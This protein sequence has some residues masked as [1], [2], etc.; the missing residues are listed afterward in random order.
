[1]SDPYWNKC[2]RGTAVWH[3]IY[4]L[5]SILTYHDYLVTAIGYNVNM[6][7]Q[8][9]EWLQCNNRE[10]HGLSEIETFVFLLFQNMFA[11]LL[12]PSYWRPGTPDTRIIRISMTST[13][14]TE[15]QSK[16][17]GS[18]LIHFGCQT[19]NCA[20]LLQLSRVTVPVPHGTGCCCSLG[21]LVTQWMYIFIS[22]QPGN[23]SSVW[24]YDATVDWLLP[25]PK[26]TSRTDT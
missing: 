2:S 25:R 10:L 14:R 17:L 24:H 8:N 19:S 22:W 7:R 6:C 21:L 26:T 4:H 12:F 9:E 15:L 11:S 23:P 13:V 18:F 3:K 1:M 16:V 5:F 20:P